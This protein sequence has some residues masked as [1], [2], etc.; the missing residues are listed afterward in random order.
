[1]PNVS[2]NKNDLLISF[3]KPLLWYLHG[4][5]S[6]YLRFSFWKNYKI[7]PREWWENTFRKSDFKRSVQI[8]HVEDLWHNLSTFCMLD[9]NIFYSSQFGHRNT[10]SGQ[11][12]YQPQ[13]DC[14]SAKWKWSPGFGKTEIK[15]LFIQSWW[16]I[17]YFI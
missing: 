9:L 14:P 6:D 12:L 11:Q 3:L 15:V 4:E 16:K 7:I 1:M 17:K 8:I 13:Y 10:T 5:S 2:Y